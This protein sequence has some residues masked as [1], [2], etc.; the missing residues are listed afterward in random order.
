MAALVRGPDTGS[1][2]SRALAVAVRVVLVAAVA[3]ATGCGDNPDSTPAHTPYTVLSSGTYHGASWQLFGWSQ[4]GQLCLELLPRG[5][6]PPA[7]S[8]APWPGAGGGAC[9]FNSAP[10]GGFS[11]GSIGPDGSDFAFGPLP[12]GATRIRVAAHEVVPTSLLPQSNGLPVGRFWILLMPAGWPTPA[13]G[14]AL[15]TPQPLD[16]HDR[17]VAFQV[18]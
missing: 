4:S 5:S 3:T 9:G 16:A 6:T 10:S 1:G 2:W 12:L 15:D 8:P 14:A 17:P 7:A 13:D 11:S 18:F